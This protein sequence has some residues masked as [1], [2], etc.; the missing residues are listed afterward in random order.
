MRHDSGTLK[1]ANAL[2]LQIDALQEEID[3][4]DPPAKPPQWLVKM[5]TPI[6]PEILAENFAFATAA[7]EK[8]VKK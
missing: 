1:R 3:E 8:A 2:R 7:Y 5:S 6:T 4:L